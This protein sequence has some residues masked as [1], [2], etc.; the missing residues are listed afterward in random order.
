MNAV[1][2]RLARVQ[3]GEILAHLLA[4][5][6]EDLRLRFGAPLGPVGIEKYVNGIDF[7]N[8]RVFGI[9][10]PELRL[11]SLAHLAV[12]LERE[13]AELGLSVA[14][15]SRRR[16]HGE[17]LLCRGATHASS[18]G[19]HM[20]Y[21][22]CLSENSALMGLARKA[23]FKIVAARGEADASKPLKES[24]PEGIA[25]ELVNDRIALVDSVYMHQAKLFRTIAKFAEPASVA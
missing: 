12:N 15:E 3:S 11:V 2:Q 17:A 10:D 9:F 24:R 13:F 5:P 25:M 14:Y 7:S 23:G 20:I 22:H 4:L 19:L 16:G 6:T 18:L 8:D 1:V 21:M